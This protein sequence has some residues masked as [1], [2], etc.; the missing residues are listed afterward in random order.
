MRNAIFGS[1]FLFDLQLLS[2]AP[3]TK[4]A[5]VQ[6]SDA[7]F[8]ELSIIGGGYSPRNP[9]ARVLGVK[10]APMRSTLSAIMSTL[11]FKAEAE[12]AAQKT[13]KGWLVSIEVPDDVDHDGDGAADYELI[14]SLLRNAYYDMSS[15][16]GISSDSARAVAVCTI[17]N[18]FHQNYSDVYAGGD[19]EVA[20]ARAIVA[21][22]DALLANELPDDPGVDRAEG[23]T[24][25]SLT[26]DVEK[27]LVE[28]ANP[29]KPYGNVTYADPGYQNDKKKRYPIDTKAHV[30]AAASYFGKASNRKKYSATQIK[31]IDGRIAAAKRRMGIGA[32]KAGPYVIEDVFKGGM[33]S[34]EAAKAFGE[35]GLYVTKGNS[36]LP[37]G[38]TL[39]EGDEIAGVVDV[40]V[41]AEES[42]GAIGTTRV[43][44]TAGTN[45]PASTPFVQAGSANLEVAVPAVATVVPNN[46]APTGETAT[47]RVETGGVAVLE[48]DAAVRAAADAVAAGQTQ[49]TEVAKAVSDAVTAAF[50]QFAPRLDEL[51]A[52]VN[53][54]IGAVKASIM[55]DVRAAIAPTVEIAQK[56]SADARGAASILDGVVQAQV[57]KA[58]EPSA[59]GGGSVANLE[60]GAQQHPATQV[61]KGDLDP[62]AVPR[63][64]KESPMA[65][66]MAKN[67]RLS[68]VAS[69]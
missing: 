41:K 33:F 49:T 57:E 43:E 52:H 32:E 68:G 13:E 23:E 18:N 27:F 20:K 1:P 36:I 60:G 54:Q 42:A 30:R 45:G 55:E 28:K 21:K 3:K 4:K 14:A 51:K 17:L 53:E 66:Y 37:V 67:M 2:D 69:T 9:D 8:T 5:H 6:L 31:A 64:A 47:G 19:G 34:Q 58:R 7:E 11:G 22:A 29:E 44:G 24:E 50:A 62:D 10:A 25:E 12:K 26:L 46:P 40:V 59:A 35:H 15:A 63:W 61:D 65:E 16:A 56:A 48:G 38:G 39:V